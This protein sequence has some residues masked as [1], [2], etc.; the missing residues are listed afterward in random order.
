MSKIPKT[1]QEVFPEIVEDLKGIY[2][3]ALQSVILYG[4]GARGEYVPG[5]SDINFLV[6]L[7]GDVAD[8]LENVLPFIPKWKKRAVAT[9]VIMTKSLIGSSVDVYPVE[10]LNMKRHYQVVFGEDALKNLVFDRKALRLQC[11]RELKGKLLLLRTGFLETE[12]RAAE[13]QR[14]LAASIM[15]FL[16]VFNALLHMQEQELP[17]GR[18]EIVAAIAHTYGIDASPFLRCIELRE[19]KQGVPFGELKAVF[20]SYIAEIRKMITM[21]DNLILP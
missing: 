8:D 14:L 18:R 9:P 6:V 15:A 19:G 21:V 13:L 4:S 3:E 7:A 10:F 20:R 11:E 5:K 12:G 1:P 17:R 16:S 2:G